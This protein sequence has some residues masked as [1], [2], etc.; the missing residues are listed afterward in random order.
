M[1][2]Q[3]CFLP[4][5]SAWRD[6]ET[7][8]LKAR[9]RPPRLLLRCPPLRKDPQ[10]PAEAWEGV[11]QAA[12]QPVERAQTVQVGRE[13]QARMELVARMQ[14]EQLVVAIR[15][16]EAAKRRAAATNALRT[17]EA[18]SAHEATAE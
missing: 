15:R 16:S 18:P 6:Q 9:S 17:M 11:S 10:S 8:L 4:D 7:Q 1:V 13:D 12:L 2:S 14:A 3:D 5:C